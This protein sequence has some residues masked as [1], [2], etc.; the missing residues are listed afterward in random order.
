M[1][2]KDKMA[3]SV[4]ADVNKRWEQGIPH[5]PK[6]VELMTALCEIDFQY[7]NDHF[8]W[9]TGGDG[10]NGETL[11]YEMDIF[12]ERKDMEAARGHGVLPVSATDMTGTRCHKCGNGSFAETSLYDDLDGVLHCN[13]C[14]HKV[15]RYWTE[16]G[17][18]AGN[19]PQELD[20][21][22]TK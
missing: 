12:F 3:K 10:D 21:V 19:D 17:K 16:K 15:D 4:E 7:C 14:G 22:A 18:P 20:D 8:C 13:K 6:S 11:M 2:N 1:V 5:H 9:K